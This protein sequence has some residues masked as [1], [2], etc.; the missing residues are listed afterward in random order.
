[1]EALGYDSL[2]VHDRTLYPVHPRA[3]YPAGDGTLPIPFKHSLD[4]IETLTFAAAYTRRVALGTS[5]LNLLWYN[6]LGVAELL[7]DVQFSP[8][9]KAVDDMLAH[10]EQLWRIARPS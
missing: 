7:F 4:P 8:G 2:W 9:V 1:V 5:V 3:P 10:M 6:R